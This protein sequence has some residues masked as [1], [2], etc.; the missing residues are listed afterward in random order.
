MP[1][2]GVPNILP[3]SLGCSSKVFT[4]SCQPK[5]CQICMS[6][7]VWKEFFS[8]FP[9]KQWGFQGIPKLP[10]CHSC[11]CKHVLNWLQIFVVNR[12]FRNVESLF[13]GTDCLTNIQH[14]WLNFESCFYIT[15]GQKKSINS[16]DEY[17]LQKRC[18]NMLLKSLVLLFRNITYT[19]RTKLILFKRI[20][21]Q[22]TS[23]GSVVLWHLSSLGWNEQPIFAW[24]VR[25]V[26]II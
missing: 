23:R 2:L 22:S 10:L 20:I 4:S 12:T 14:T 8:E 18:L 6:Q 9:T 7:K 1:F 26:Y 17:I 25:A 11:C 19:I 3:W 13:V 16:S 21:V 5:K 15:D 24:K